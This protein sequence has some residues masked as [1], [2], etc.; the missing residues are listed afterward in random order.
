[1]SKTRVQTKGQ[2]VI[3][4]AVREA[5]GVS[6]GDYV[7]VETSEDRRAAV[8]RPVRGILEFVAEEGGI[9]TPQALRGA[10]E[11]RTRRD[12]IEAHVED[13]HRDR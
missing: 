13:A 5:I 7:E 8:I 4:R 11:K 9:P 10:D 12:A 1:M 2:V 3:P 6:P